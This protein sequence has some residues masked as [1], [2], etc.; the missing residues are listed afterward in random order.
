MRRVVVA[1]ALVATACGSPAPATKP[2]TTTTSEAPKVFADYAEDPCAILSE[3]DKT[4]LGVVAGGENPQPTDPAAC[5]WVA[6]PGIVEIKIYPASDEVPVYAAKP[7][8]VALTVA[9]RPATRIAVETSCFLHVTV[10]ARQSFR[11]G[12][13]G[14]ATEPC[15]VTVEFATVVLEN[16]G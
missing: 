15:G 2:A 7:G 9:G 5:S 3:D 10:A 13:T 6:G 11:V 8:A 1:L 14:D 4:A 16:L 12:A